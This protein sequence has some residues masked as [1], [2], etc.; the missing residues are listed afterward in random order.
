M[1]IGFSIFKF[2]GLVSG[3]GVVVEGSGLEAQV[4]LGL[5]LGGVFEAR[6][7]AGKHGVVR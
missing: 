3:C 1:G 2:Q 7:R 4:F 6:P 5:G